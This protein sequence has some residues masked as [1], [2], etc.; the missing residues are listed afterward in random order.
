MDY[1]NNANPDYYSTFTSGEF[2]IHFNQMPAPERVAFDLGGLE[3]FPYGWSLSGQQGYASGSQDTLRSEVTFGK[4]DDSPSTALHIS[5]SPES[6]SLEASHGGWTQDYGQMSFQ[7]HYWSTTERYNQPYYTGTISRDDS[8]TSTA[9]LEVPPA[10]SAPSQCEPLFF[11]QELSVFR[12]QTGLLDCWGGHR[13]G[14]FTSTFH[15]V[16]VLASSYNSVDT[17]S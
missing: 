1:F 3:T 11:Q 7:Q 12:P 10:I 16:G 4:H 8:P 14:P 17:S 2:N 15:V 13:S 9:P 6:V 5:I